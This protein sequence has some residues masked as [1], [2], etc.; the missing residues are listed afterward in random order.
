MEELDTKAANSILWDNSYAP[1][2][3]CTSSTGFR[4]SLLNY[5]VQETTYNIAEDF[6]VNSFLKRDD[7]ETEASI[8][9]YLS[10]AGLQTVSMIDTEYKD[11][12]HI[13]LPVS[14]KISMSLGAC[15]SIRRSIRY[16]TGD[17]ISFNQLATLLRAGN[18]IS[19]ISE[20]SSHSGEK[21]SLRQRTVPSGGGLYPIHLYIL[22][23]KVSGLE[24][25]LYRYQPIKDVLI[26]SSLR[27]SSIE[28][29]EK[30]FTGASDMFQTAS[31]LF[32]LV[33]KPWRSM[34]KY[35]NKGLRFVL[36]EVGGISQNIHLSVTSLGLGSAD[37]A[38][39]YEDEIHQILEFD[40]LSNVVLH[41]I[42]IG[43]PGS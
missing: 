36:H 17:K 40:G 18:G 7:V 4:T 27:D 5:S 30:S 42:F 24:R 32:L 38:G 23:L 37:Y 19:A 21:V 6:I 25:G 26:P 41:S 35:G 31:L 14:D 11:E 20:G 1:I 12:N 9:Y 43:M 34:R 33:G 15:I 3:P 28:D 29:F 39:F 10:G 2:S 16:Y 8:S 13:Q 22:A